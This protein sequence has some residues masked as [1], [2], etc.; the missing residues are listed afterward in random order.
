[1]S[2][3]YVD[4][5]TLIKLVIR[6]PGTDEAQH[7][8]DRATSLVSAATLAVEAR[9]ALA[10]AHRGRR[11]QQ[12]QFERAK[13]SLLQL[14]EDV[15]ALDIVDDLLTSAAELAESEALRGYDA[16]H[17]AAAIESGASVLTS[18]DTALCEAASRNGF[19]VANPMAIA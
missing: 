12:G 10:A 9:A 16:I 13:A 17:L 2:T 4:T 14:L 15:T 1:M 11:F 3:T 8:W 7:I 19:V 6:E 18:A 5:S